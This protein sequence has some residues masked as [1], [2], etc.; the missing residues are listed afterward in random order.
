MERL[1]VSTFIAA[2]QAA[3]AWDQATHLDE[4]K[5]HMI[6]NQMTLP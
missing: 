2:E 5:S 1:R 3:G 4:L 6:H